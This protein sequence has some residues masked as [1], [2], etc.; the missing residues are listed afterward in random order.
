VPQFHLQ[1][2]QLVFLAVLATLE[3]SK[4]MPLKK[5]DSLALGQ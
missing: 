5:N 4:S 1:A 3:L 2:F